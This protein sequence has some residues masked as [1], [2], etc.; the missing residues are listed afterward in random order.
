MNIEITQKANILIAE[1]KIESLK[2]LSKILEEE[3][4][5]VRQAIDGEMAL[6]AVETEVPDLILLGVDLD[7]ID[8]HQLCKKL[9][10][11]DKTA[12]IPIIF[13]SEFDDFEQKIKA[14]QLGKVDYII[15]PYQQ[16]GSKIT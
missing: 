16:L 5:Q 13:L 15:K 1:N 4:Y 11:Q 14:L 7:K 2:L 6:I 12:D 10:Q 9:K 8:G 3:S